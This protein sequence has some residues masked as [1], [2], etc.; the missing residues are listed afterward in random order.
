MGVK[1]S[2]IFFCFKEN[3]FVCFDFVFP[4][5]ILWVNHVPGTSKVVKDRWWEVLLDTPSRIT[6]TKVNPFD[7][8]FLLLIEQEKQTRVNTSVCQ[9]LVLRILHEDCRRDV[10]DRCEGWTNTVSL[11]DLTESSVCS[12]SFNGARTL[13]F[14]RSFYVSIEF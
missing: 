13:C 8:V 5:K 10:T 9:P 3:H 7:S 14:G 12:V 1:V 6:E 2:I 11:V 4:V